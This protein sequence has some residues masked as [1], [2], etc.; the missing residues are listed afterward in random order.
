MM[1]ITIVV[2]IFFITKTIT[3]MIIVRKLVI[4]IR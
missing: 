1:M 4:K 3:L 2:T